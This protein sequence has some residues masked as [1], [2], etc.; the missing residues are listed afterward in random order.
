M[1]VPSLQSLCVKAV[2][3]P[4]AL[5]G[6]SA[7]HLPRVRPSL[8]RTIVRALT[9]STS[10]V[11]GA[12]PPAALCA[13]GLRVLSFAGCSKLSPAGLLE[14]LRGGAGVALLGLDLTSFFALEDAHVGEVLVACPN[15]RYLSLVDCRKLTDRAVEFL[16]ERGGALRH[17]DLGG[18]ACVTRRGVAA[19]LAHPQIKQ[20]VGLGLSG[21][22]GVDAELLQLLASRCTRLQRLALG[23]Q[24]AGDRAL[25]D[26]L[27]ASAE[28]LVALE[29]QWPRGPLTDTVALALTGAEG[30]FPQL[31]FLNVQG[32]KGLSVDGLCAILNTHARRSGGE[33]EWDAHEVLEWRSL[34]GLP[35]TKI[36][37]AAG[38]GGG[39]GGMDEEGGD[40]TLPPLLR[41]LGQGLCCVVCRF[42]SPDGGALAALRA[43][44]SAQ[45]LLCRLE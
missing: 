20:F 44:V 43:Y 4:H 34:C 26:A 23:Y 13:S 21:L 22:D 11:D 37:A 1:Q 39:G 28:T 29:L 36:A 16:V 9:A 8:L 24:Y 25:C 27:R 18:C 5:S 12:L 35:A 14:L 6:T 31:R 42:A 32:C 2:T 38:A 15:L 10:W 7:S 45:A 40:T 41:R 33:P 19:L 17:V 30:T 3:Q